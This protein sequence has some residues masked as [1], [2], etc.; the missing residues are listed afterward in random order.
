[1]SRKLEVTLSS[2]LHLNH[3]LLYRMQGSLK[4]LQCNIQR[5][6]TEMNHSHW[7]SSHPP[8]SQLLSSKS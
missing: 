4:A 1:M 6:G 2:Y 7:E 5:T 8:S 3:P